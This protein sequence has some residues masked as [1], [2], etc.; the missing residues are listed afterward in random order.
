MKFKNRVTLMLIALNIIVYL[1]QVYLRSKHPEA[2]FIFMLENAISNQGQI[3]TIITN[4]F[5]HKDIFHLGMNM[6][7]LYFLGSYIEKNMKENK[8]LMLYFVSGLVASLF[9]LLYVT[10][11]TPNLVIGASGAIFGLW[12]Y[13]SLYKNEFNEFLLMAGVTNIAMIAGGLPIA[14]YAHLGGALAGIA[15][16]KLEK[17]KKTIYKL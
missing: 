4:M 15:I 17:R 13:F 6:L 11:I 16:W 9:S 7:G 10:F 3:K 1:Y 8:Y 14:W 2:E 12:A 5:I